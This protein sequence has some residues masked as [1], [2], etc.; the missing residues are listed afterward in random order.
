M[1]R[2]AAWTFVGI[3]SASLLYRFVERQTQMK[4]VVDLSGRN[5]VVTGATAGIG[6]AIAIDLAKRGANVIVVG[7]SDKGVLDE[8]KQVAPQGAH[9]FVSCDLTLVSNTRKC[10]RDIVDK[11]SGGVI[12]VL[13]LSAGMGTIDSRT[14]TSEGL[15]QKLA[16]HYY[17]RVAAVLEV[18][19]ALQKSSL[20]ASVLFVLSGGVHSAFHP[21]NDDYEL[22]HSY[23]LQNAANAA[24]FYTDLAVDS[25]SRLPSLSNVR[26]THASPGFV[27]TSWGTELP[28]PLRWA[29]RAMQAIAATSADVCAERMALAMQLDQQQQQ[30]QQKEGYKRNGFHVC[31]QYGNELKPLPQHTEQERIPLWD[32]TLQV[33]NSKK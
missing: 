19:D 22:R 29:V 32:H 24:G 31:D 12:D 4:H 21:P 9:R 28:A 26:I 13:V 1:R 10:M 7:R 27:A 2:A 33:V 5:A 17:T 16:L 20:P 14:E 23:S 6:R 11:S 18:Q 3:V 8:L 15:D 25:L 30:Q